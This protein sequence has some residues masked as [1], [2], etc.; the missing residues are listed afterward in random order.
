MVY[1][2]TH[3]SSQHPHLDIP[4]NQTG[5]VPHSRHA[6]GLP[7]PPP[8]AAPV[9]ALPQIDKGYE[10]HIDIAPA[11]EPS[12]N[13][14]RLDTDKVTDN[15]EDTDN[16]DKDWFE[17]AIASVASLTT[18]MITTAPSTRSTQKA[19][20]SLVQV[21]KI[22][23]HEQT[24]KNWDLI[25]ADAELFENSM[26][27]VLQRLSEARAEIAEQLARQHEETDG[28]REEVTELRAARGLTERPW[29][30]RGAI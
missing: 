30:H 25:S 12:Y 3:T 21:L 10:S 14:T 17:K 13:P 7:G 22:L 26:N 28:L 19:A 5:S 16:T 27:G 24:D 29:Q 15:D 23:G 2:L 6:C 11:S 1:K 8:G 20:W 18:E 9:P 4:A